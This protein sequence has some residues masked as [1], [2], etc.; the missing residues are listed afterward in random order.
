[1]NVNN[2]SKIELIIIIDFIIEFHIIINSQLSNSVAL[3]DL[4]DLTDVN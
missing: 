2:F 1:M 3:T 4:I